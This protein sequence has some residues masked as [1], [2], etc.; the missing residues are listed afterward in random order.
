M[1]SREGRMNTVPGCPE[2]TR[3]QD[4]LKVSFKVLKYLMGAFFYRFWTSAWTRIG[5]RTESDLAAVKDP[6]RKRLIGQ[7][8]D[9]IEAFANFGCI[10][11]G[12]LQIIALNF[13]QTIWQKYAGW[14]RTVTSI[15][16]SEEIVKSVVQHD[17]L[18]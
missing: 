18:P 10:A 16:P 3:K 7:T 5:K 15:V 11:T 13:G 8:T 1:D 14:L 4:H 2:S 12:I 6:T 9:E 17:V